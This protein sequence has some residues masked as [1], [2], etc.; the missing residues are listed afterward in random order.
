MSIEF[1]SAL[2]GLIDNEPGDPFGMLKYGEDC[3][4]V[5][6]EITMQWEYG[7]D[8]GRCGM[9]IGSATFDREDL[10]LNAQE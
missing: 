5:W 6:N 4:P 7:A 9:D 8:L 3:R 10:D 2:F 1:K